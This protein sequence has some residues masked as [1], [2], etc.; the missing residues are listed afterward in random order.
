MAIIVD[1]VS[2]AN[3]DGACIFDFLLWQLVWWYVIWLWGG[4]GCCHVLRWGR[5]FQDGLFVKI[6]MLGM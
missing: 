4:R 3:L 5:L 1:H 6:S 2:V